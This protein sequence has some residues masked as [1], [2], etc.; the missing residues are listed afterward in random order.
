MIVMS[1]L[2]FIVYGDLVN[3]AWRAIQLINLTVGFRCQI[4]EPNI[5]SY[6]V[7]YHRHLHNNG[8]A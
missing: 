6:T 1:K 3:M 4:K 7:G 2:P 8:M 5:I